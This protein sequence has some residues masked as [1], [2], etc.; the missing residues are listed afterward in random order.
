MACRRASSVDAR[1]RAQS[2]VPRH[3]AEDQAEGAQGLEGRDVGVLD[4]VKGQ[5]PGRGFTHVEPVVG[6]ARLEGLGQRRLAL[7]R[8]VDQEEAI[9]LLGGERLLEVA[10]PGQKLALEQPGTQRGHEP[11]A[12]SRV[13]Q[14]ELVPQL[15]VKHVGQRVAVGGHGKGSRRVLALEEQPRVGALLGGLRERGL[16]GESSAHELRG[17]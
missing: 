13:A 16:E 6:E 8:H 11:Q 10:F 3:G 5:E 7:L 2:T 17:P 1:T 9:S 4:A 14:D 12:H 15:A